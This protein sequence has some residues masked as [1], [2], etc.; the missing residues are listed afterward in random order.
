MSYILRCLQECR[1]L[2]ESEAEGEVGHMKADIMKRLNDMGARLVRQ[3]QAA[4]I[5]AQSKYIQDVDQEILPVKVE[6]QLGRRED[7]PA[8]EWQSIYIYDDNNLKMRLTK[9]IAERFGLDS[10]LSFES[11]E[12]LSEFLRRLYQQVTGAVID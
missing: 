9:T 10:Y 6:I 3:A 2:H 5:E 7:H 4:G 12:D 1:R 11:M 8:S